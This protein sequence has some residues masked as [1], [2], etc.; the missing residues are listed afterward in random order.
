[1][2]KHKNATELGCHELLVDTMRRLNRTIGLKF[3]DA[4]PA[5]KV[6]NL[7]DD[8]G[9]TFDEADALEVDS[10]LAQIRKLGLAGINSN[11]V[12]KL[13]WYSGKRGDEA[14]STWTDADC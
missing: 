4:Q 13:G 3:D 11:P 5:I 1:M 10:W 12:M 6:Q 8:F 14:R 2:I 7:N 9:T